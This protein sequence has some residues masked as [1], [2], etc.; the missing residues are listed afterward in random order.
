[1]RFPLY[2]KGVIQDFE[3][4]GGGGGGGGGGSKV[5]RFDPPKLGTLR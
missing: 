2:Y 1:M 5:A 4:G 3:V